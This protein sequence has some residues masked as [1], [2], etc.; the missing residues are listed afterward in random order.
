MEISLQPI[1]END[2]LV[3]RKI[4][5]DY[6]KEIDPDFHHSKN[7][8]DRYIEYIFYNNKRKL[9]WVFWKK[10]RI[11]LLIYYFYN[12]SPV[13]KGLHISEFYIFPD[14]RKRK[15]ATKTLDALENSFPDCQEIKL[16]ALPENESGL[17]FWKSRGFI[18][19]KYIMRKNKNRED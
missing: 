19:K 13:K 18:I 11:G 1:G 15:F 6:W 14:Y 10:T 9:F 12:I 17:G 4:L 3:L 2:K 8:L 7:L 5:H 16:E